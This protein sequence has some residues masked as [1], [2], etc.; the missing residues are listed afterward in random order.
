MRWH[1]PVIPAA[2]EAAFTHRMILPAMTVYGAMAQKYATLPAAGREHHRTVM[3]IFRAQ[4][5]HAM[6]IQMRV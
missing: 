3:I 4:T 5:I 1:A 2:A 6:K